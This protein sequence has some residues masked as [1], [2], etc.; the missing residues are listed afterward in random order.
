MEER[1]PRTTG[2]GQHAAD[3][4]PVSGPEGYAVAVAFCLLL[5]PALVPVV[6]LSDVAA[7]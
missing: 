4:P 6:W 1:S 7:V 3:T 2:G 5:R